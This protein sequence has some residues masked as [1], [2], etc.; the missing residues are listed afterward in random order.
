MKG[1][2]KVCELAGEYACLALSYLFLINIEEVELIKMYERLVGIK[3]I[4]REF[5]VR[6]ANKLIVF[7]GSR[8]RVVKSNINEVIAGERYAGLWSNDCTGL[9]HWVVM[10]DGEVIYDPYGKSTTVKQ[11]KFTGDVRRVI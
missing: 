1:F 4:D 11:G 2:Q 8:K 9:S 10:Q 7:F 3:A 6:D 5:F